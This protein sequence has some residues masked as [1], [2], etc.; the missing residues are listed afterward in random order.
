MKSLSFALRSA[1]RYVKPLGVAVVSM[2]LLVGV[3]LLAPWL[4]KTW[5]PGLPIRLSGRMLWSMSHAWP[6]WR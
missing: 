2:I 6:W 1:R 3:Q 4:V 5:S